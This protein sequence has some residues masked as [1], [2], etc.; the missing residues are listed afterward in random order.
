MLWQ[1]DY[2]AS[3]IIEAELEVSLRA[4]EARRPGVE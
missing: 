4:V 3:R 1:P 2:A